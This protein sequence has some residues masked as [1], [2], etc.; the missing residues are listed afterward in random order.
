M[1]LYSVRNNVGDNVADTNKY[2]PMAWSLIHWAEKLIPEVKAN[3]TRHCYEV[4][5]TDNN[6]EVIAN[7]WNPYLDQVIF[8]PLIHARFKEILLLGKRQDNNAKLIAEWRENKILPNCSNI[9]ETT[10]FPLADYQKLVRHNLLTNSGYCLYMEQGTGKTAPVISTICHEANKKDTNKELYRAIVVCPKSVR[11]N[12]K[13]E[14]QKFATCNGRITIIR[15]DKVIREKLLLQSLVKTQDD[16]DGNNKFS[17]VICSYGSLA[18]TIEALTFKNIMGRSV[19]EGVMWDMCV[20]DESH[21][22]KTPVAQ[23]T[24]AA[25]RLRDASEKR[26]VLTGTPFT[27]SLFDVWSQFE[28]IGKGYSGFSTFS[29]FKAFYGSY[30]LDQISGRKELIGTTNIPLLQERL[31]RLS[32]MITKKEALPNLPDKVYD[33]VECTMT[34]EQRKIY[35]SAATKVFIEIENQ[36]QHDAEADIPN[37]MT[38]QNILVRLLR[39]AQITSGF[40]KYDD[41][42]S[43]EGTLIR[44]GYIDRIDPNNKLEMLVEL[45]KEKE[46]HEK[47]IIWSNFVPA[48]KFIHSR[49]QIENIDCVKFYGDTSDD[50]REKAVN[51]FNNDINCK[52]FVGNPAAGGVGLN[53]LGNSNEEYAC[54]HEIYYSQNWSSS[55]RSQSEDRAHRKGTKRRVRVTDLIIQGTIDEE[56]RARVKDKREAAKSIQDVRLILNRILNGSENLVANG[57]DD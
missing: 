7:T 41:E 27:N 25:H 33:V 2:P 49:L 12:W 8:D 15:G 28:A 35:I 23:R 43:F 31:A 54:D 39:L 16:I 56:I 22:I 13:L 3:K 52:V 10:D 55:D 11:F 38:I 29:A 9:K 48:I 42:Y 51:R 32:F 45:L 36:I 44:K 17:V 4:P 21:F 18:K 30:K 57:E 47:T 5:L 1:H 26:L 46:P 50:D 6:V 20:F 40:V 24:K 19:K 53:L 34:E 37:K 14:F